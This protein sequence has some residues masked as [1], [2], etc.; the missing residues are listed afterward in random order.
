M[1]VCF[2]YCHQNCLR[3]EESTYNRFADYLV[4]SGCQFSA[5]SKGLSWERLDG[6]DI[7]V[8][9]N[10]TESLFD[11]TEISGI[12]NFVKSGKSL[13]IFGDAGGDLSAQT[14]L[15]AICSYFG[16]TFNDDIVFDQDYNAGDP[17]RILIRDFSAHEITKT[18][19]KVFYA[20]GCT[21][22]IVATQ[23]PDVNTLGL[24]FTSTTTQRKVFIA[25]QWTEAG[26]INAP[27]AVKVNYYQGRIFAIGNLSILSS[28]SP[29]YGWD[30]G[31]NSLFIQGAIAWLMQGAA[32]GHDISGEIIVPAQIDKELYQWSLAAAEKR[33]WTLSQI[34]NYALRVFRAQSPK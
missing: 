30:A 31:D 17:T 21:I 12:L 5:I 34:I 3:L 14:N 8:I 16:F 28:L 26:A 1:K 18:L 9:G 15:N 6:N 24:A 33:R 27:V 2:D 10:P 32:Q 23:S 22:N 13:M 29:K 4:W 25:D 7:L 19:Q 11:P 20:S